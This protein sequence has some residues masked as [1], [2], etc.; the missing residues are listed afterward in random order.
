[1]GREGRHLLVYRVRQRRAANPRCC[2]R[3]GAKRPMS[4]SSVLRLGYSYRPVTGRKRRQDKRKWTTLHAMV[5]AAGHTGHEWM[6]YSMPPY[7]DHKVTFL[8]SCHTCD[9]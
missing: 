1:M 2:R 3:Q 6:G 8:Y 7:G 4:D 5:S 9:E